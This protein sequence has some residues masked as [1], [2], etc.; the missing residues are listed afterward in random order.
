MRQFGKSGH[1][2]F[3]V[4]RGQD[5]RPVE[6]SRVRKSI[7]AERTFRQ[8]LIDLPDIEEQLWH[9]AEEVGERMCAADRLGRT[10]T[11]KIKYADFHQITRARTPGGLLADADSLFEAIK[12]LMVDAFKPGDHIRLLGITVSNLARDREQDPQLEFRF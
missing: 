2:Y 10:V 1:Y 11:L 8:D 6:P 12:P 9:I 7:G 5:D 4:S 3:Q